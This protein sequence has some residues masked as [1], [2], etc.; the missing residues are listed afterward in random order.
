MRNVI[1]G[2]PCSV[3]PHRKHNAAT[4]NETSQWPGAICFRHLRT[5]PL[6]DADDDIPSIILHGVPSV[7]DEVHQDP[8]QLASISVYQGGRFRQLV[9]DEDAFPREATQQV[10]QVLHQLIHIHQRLL[11]DASA[12]EGQK[13]ASEICA[14]LQALMHVLQLLPTLP[15]GPHAQGKTIRA[16]PRNG[17]DVIEVM[18]NS[19]RHPAQSLH[20]LTLLKL[21]LQLF[22]MR[23]VRGDHHIV[24][25]SAF[26]VTYGCNAHPAGN[27][28]SV[29]PAVL[30][31]T[32]VRFARVYVRPN[33]WGQLH[34]AGQGGAEHLPQH[35]VL[36]PPHHRGTGRIHVA[37]RQVRI[38][39][40]HRFSRMPN[41]RHY[42]RLLPVLL[43]QRGDVPHDAL[44]RNTATLLIAYHDSPLFQPDRV[45][46]LGHTTFDG[47]DAVQV[48]RRHDGSK[49][50]PVL[51]RDNLGH[52]IRVSIAFLRCVT[53]YPG[54]GRANVLKPLLGS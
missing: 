38:K 8:L 31:L 47:V 34:A 14:A 45:S 11:Q 37:H 50:L 32:N 1:S 21:K 18:R 29:L 40:H 46:P 30:H 7:R 52:Y 44:V 17:E 48:G 15:I 51:R 19:R 36:S 9:A 35:L 43:P 49:T 27:L 22:L 53:R 26:L 25:R 23:D 16:P 41:C 6:S 5:H 24:K 28:S 42:S 2:N 54:H 13:T 3:I 12:R 20:L 4:F 39:H 10:L 33:G